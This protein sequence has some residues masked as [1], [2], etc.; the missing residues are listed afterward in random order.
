[1]GIT[2]EELERKETM[3]YDSEEYRNFQ[4]EH[5]SVGKLI[6]PGTAKLWWTWGDILDVYGVLDDG[7]K[8]TNIGRIYFL[9]APDSDIW[10]NTYDLP[11]ATRDEFWRR[12]RAGYYSDD[13]DLL[14][15]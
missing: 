15:E 11:A 8:E 5:N 4:H 1:M 13:H 7:A 9:R 14:R 12:L 6:D 3:K 2:S 10:V